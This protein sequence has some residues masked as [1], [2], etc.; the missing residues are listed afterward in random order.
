LSLTP[1]QQQQVRDILTSKV[2]SRTEL[3][4]SAETGSLPFEEVKARRNKVA[5]EEEQ[6]ITALLSPEQ[7]TAYQEM[8]KEEDAPGIKN[9]ASREASRLASSLNLA[10]EERERAASI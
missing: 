10:P 9:W 5:Q 6:A 7:L 4:V 1:A 8:Q 2:D 3:E